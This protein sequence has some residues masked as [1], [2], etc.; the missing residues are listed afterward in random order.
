[1]F[2]LNLKLTT[3]DTLIVFRYQLSLDTVCH[4][5]H[6]NPGALK[7]NVVGRRDQGFLKYKNKYFL[8]KPKYTLI[9][10]FSHSLK[11]FTPKNEL[12]NQVKPEG[13]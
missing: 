12:C 5:L 11:N 9:A 2:I 3:I 4:L 7:Y 13:F 1:M 10:D 8:L 6:Y